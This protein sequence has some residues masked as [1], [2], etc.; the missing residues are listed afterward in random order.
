MHLLQK[1]SEE[2][3]LFDVRLDKS[4]HKILVEH[5]WPGNV[6]ELSNVLEWTLSSL[7]GNCIRDRDLPFYL[8]PGMG[9]LPSEKH[10]PM[11][12]VQAHAEAQAIRQ[13]LQEADFNKAQAARILGIHRTLL[14]KK[15]KKYGVD[16]TSSGAG[17]SP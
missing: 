8:K 10:S 14:Y 3:D 15:M 1:L 12:E 2:A 5:G 4:A 9:I 11:R 17:S 7:E 16:A 13:A 6:R